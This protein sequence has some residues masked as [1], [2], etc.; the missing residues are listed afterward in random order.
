MLSAY[1][2]A[3]NRVEAADAAGFFG[4]YGEAAR[5]LRHLSGTTDAAAVGVLDLYRGHA[6]EV[7]GVVD[8]EVA[9]HAAALR[10]GELPPSC[11]VRLVS[12]SAPGA[13]RAAPAATP[14]VGENMFRRSGR[15]WEVR[16]AGGR[17]FTVLPTVG[18]NYLHHLLSRPD[19]PMPAA[20]LVALASGEP[21]RI[22]PG[23]AG[24]VLDDAARRTY[25]ARF[26]DLRADL[27]AARRDNDPVW[28]SSA[29][30]T[31]TPRPGALTWT[32]SYT[33]RSW[34]C[35]SGTPGG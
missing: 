35:V 8:R 4:R 16:F 24:D 1:V 31:R 30:R 18:A 32:A 28:R 11:L 13:D 5:A 14:P 29:R 25:Q 10:R 15:A 7:T 17:R 23:G 33:R 27:D 12:D 26:D 6:H 20:E 34:R 19:V 3:A 21:H 2:Q 9:R 22:V